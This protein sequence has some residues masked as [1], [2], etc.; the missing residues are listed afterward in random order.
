VQQTT[1][2]R[3]ETHHQKSLVYLAVN[4]KMA[5]EKAASD[6]N[7]IV[8]VE[9]IRRTATAI[10]HHQDDDVT[11]GT[12]HSSTPLPQISSSEVVASPVAVVAEASPASPHSSG[13]AVIDFSSDA[14]GYSSHKRQREFDDDIVDVDDPRQDDVSSAALYEDEDGLNQ[15]EDAKSDVG[16]SRSD[17]GG[18]RSSD[19][20]N[21]DNQSG[22]DK[23]DDIDSLEN[24]GEGG[25][26]SR[27]GAV[28]ASTP[29][30]YGL[31]LTENDSKFAKIVQ[32]SVEEFFKVHT[33]AQRLMAW[34]ITPSAVRRTRGV[35]MSH[36]LTA[37][38]LTDAGSNEIRVVLRHN[39]VSE[40]NI[41]RAVDRYR[42]SKSR[43]P[44]VLEQWT[45]AVQQDADL[46]HSLLRAL[47]EMQ[48]LPLA[49]VVTHRS[50][51]IW[52]IRFGWK[53]SL[54]ELTA[55]AEEENLK[56]ARELALIGTSGGQ[57][58]AIESTQNAN[59]S[60]A[61]SQGGNMYMLPSPQDVPHWL[62]PFFVERVIPFVRGP[63]NRPPVRLTILPKYQIPF[64]RVKEIP[65]IIRAVRY[66]VI[67]SADHATSNRNNRN[68]P[69][70]GNNGAPAYFLRRSTRVIVDD[71]LRA[72]KQH[73]DVPLAFEMLLEIR[74]LSTEITELSK[75]HAFL[76]SSV[77]GDCVR[78]RGF[79]QARPELV[80]DNG[81]R[82]ICLPYQRLILNAEELR[83]LR[84]VCR[85]FLKR[86][87]HGNQVRPVK[88]AL[89]LMM[90]DDIVLSLKKDF[91]E[92]IEAVI[93]G[94]E[95]IL[96]KATNKVLASVKNALSDWAESGCP[97]G[98]LAF[99]VDDVFDSD[100]SFRVKTFAQAHNLQMERVKTGNVVTFTITAAPGS[101]P[102]RSSQ[103]Q[104]DQ[105]QRGARQQH[106]LSA[107]PPPPPPPPPSHQQHMM[108]QMG[109]LQ[110][111]MDQQQRGHLHLL[112]APPPPPPPPPMQQQHQQQPSHQQAQHQQQMHQQQ[113][114]QVHQ[115]QLQQQQQ[116][117]QQQ[118]H[119]QSQ[120]LM[121][122][123][124][125]ISPR[126]RTALF[127]DVAPK[128]LYSTIA[129][130]Q[131]V[132]P[133]GITCR[134]I[135]QRNQLVLLD[136][137]K[138]QGFRAETG[139]ALTNFST[140]IAIGIQTVRAHLDYQ[141][142]IMAPQ[143]TQSIVPPPPPPMQQLQH[144]QA[145]SSG[146]GIAG[147]FR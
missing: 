43:Q 6:K 4:Y 8:F 56:A 42:T 26:N 107:P 102:Q 58:A 7:D 103:Q 115:Q 40:R 34:T 91:P 127:A 110:Q 111:Q 113:Q 72:A 63:L 129:L 64:L 89:P 82:L 96:Q 109:H 137:I 144:Q 108:Q 48:V 33:C 78:I 76:Y 3:Q 70:Q 20:D 119:Q 24:D 1:V 59:L 30:G 77:E 138:R 18:D 50:H 10:I 35:A 47:P 65:N 84:V 55:A 79:S 83:D 71:I 19:D 143:F 28:A 93:S 22:D 92:Q 147:L 62:R 131:N 99:R 98:S 69:Q 122:S 13:S 32:R 66:E 51:S 118:Q 60:R 36:K 15:D 86:S 105:Q 139:E 114:Q 61:S 2:L 37:V 123:Y 75:M 104:M 85:D 128:D 16:S 81:Q 52:V 120:A 87:A 74:F 145:M 133:S 90:F 21:D 88:L 116:Q 146:Y 124:H 23:N 29:R 135:P 94:T 11:A 31:C 95:I 17:E 141:A 14:V 126:P 67:S 25:S 53:L 12:I 57:R 136:H 112:P 45:F 101:T 27:S 100:V 142:V 140:S 73:P 44:R 97:T 132:L 39:T 5:S 46:A 9:D 41:R 68:G 80:R 117:Q 54:G 125:Y 121:D 106:P 49:E 38:F 130:G 134:F